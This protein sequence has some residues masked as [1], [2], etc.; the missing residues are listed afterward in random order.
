LTRGGFCDII[1]RMTKTAMP[2]T[3]RIQFE[4]HMKDAGDIT[5]L[6][7]ELQRYL[8]DGPMGKWV[9]H[10][11]VFGQ[12]PILPHYLNAFYQQKIEDVKQAI[13]EKD[14]DTFIF[15]HE[16]P[17]RLEA[18][19]T[20][21]EEFYVS[22]PKFC[23]LLHD[24][25]TNSENIWQNQDDWKFLLDGYKGPALRRTMDKDD[26]AFFESLGK[27]FTVYRGCG[28]LN[29]KGL[30]WTTDLER[31]IFFA[32]RYYRKNENRY[33]IEG[34]APKKMVYFASQRR[35]E[36]EVVVDPNYVTVFKEDLILGPGIITA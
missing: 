19:M 13:K 6:H 1:R 32:K 28:D 3:V 25:W 4:E 24:V 35:N 36:S 7:P 8:W 34:K 14:Y 17:H 5:K 27:D 21:Q 15:L 18:L 9:R 26:K 31:A 29:K 20:V 16:K 23:R 12:P 22:T 2:E 11:L 30:S 33:V 10:P